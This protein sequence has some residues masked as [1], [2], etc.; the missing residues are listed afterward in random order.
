M[1]MP[2][3]EDRGCRHL[4]R[5]KITKSRVTQLE[6]DMRLV[7]TAMKKKMKHSQRTGKPVEQPGEQPI[8]L[9]LALCDNS[10]NPLKN[11]KS[12]TTHFL[13]SHYREAA[14]PVFLLSLPWKPQC[15]I[16]E[17]MFIINT[18]PLGSHTV[19]SDYAKFLYTR[20]KTSVADLGWF[21]GFHGTP[22]S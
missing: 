10:G 6:R 20:F 13:D 8:E 15:C 11:Q 5:K 14:T 19:I 2:Q 17:G 18:T 7:I 12:Y 22:L 3:R 9:P 21:L 1:F 16:I 4:V